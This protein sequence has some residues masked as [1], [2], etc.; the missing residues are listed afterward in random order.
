M[1]VKNYK[2]LLFLFVSFF[3]TCQS[4]S[5]K[6]SKEHSN[7]RIIKKGNVTEITSTDIES[8]GKILD[9][10]KYMPINVEYRYVIIDNSGQNE[11]LTVPGPSDYSLEAILYFDESTF[12]AIYDFEKNL[13]WK[14]QNHKKEEFNFEWLPQ[15]VKEELA[16][17]DKT[18]YK[19]HPDFFF[20]TGV[21]GKAWYLDKKI[22]L[23]EHTN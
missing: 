6:K 15:K 22:L 7:E 23:Q 10:G 11:R 9:F 19:G 13:E 3:M 17:D 20:G 16:Q 1:N 5:D 14:E 21:N 12:H 18:N 8:L 2:W 4:D